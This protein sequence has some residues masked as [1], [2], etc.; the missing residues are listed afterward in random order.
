MWL[1][2]K[3]RTNSSYD[4]KLVFPTCLTWDACMSFCRTTFPEW[5]RISSYPNLKFMTFKVLKK[6]NAPNKYLLWR[7]A[8]GYFSV[9]FCFSDVF[10]RCQCQLGIYDIKTV[11]SH[12]IYTPLIHGNSIIKFHNQSM[13][14][15]VVLD[16][17]FMWVDRQI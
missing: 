17:Y 8:R 7:K 13:S 11:S 14:I 5:T 16:K 10:F 15:P 4:R 2:Q 6:F 1:T 9:S 3:S 12:M